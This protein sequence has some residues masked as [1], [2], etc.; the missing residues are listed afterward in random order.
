MILS[1]KCTWIF[2]NNTF[3]EIHNPQSDILDISL[4]F[5]SLFRG[6]LDTT[7]A[8]Q[9]RSTGD[10]PVGQPAKAANRASRARPRGAGV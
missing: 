5:S 9:L 3:D 7:G 10:C 4:I 8:T 1:K 6:P 2:S